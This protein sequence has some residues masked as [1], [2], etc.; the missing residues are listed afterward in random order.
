MGVSGGITDACTGCEW[1]R[2]AEVTVWIHTCLDPPLVCVIRGYCVLVQR[3]QKSLISNDV[4]HARTI[5]LSV[6]LSS[7]YSELLRTIV[8]TV[9][10]KFSTENAL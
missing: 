1:G 7:E 9:W 6:M 2:P 10:Q 5:D 3:E 8:M 4:M